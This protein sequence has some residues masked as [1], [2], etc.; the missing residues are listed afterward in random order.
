MSSAIDDDILLDNER[1]TVRR[2]GIAPRVAP[3]SLLAADDHLW[4]IIK[5]GLLKSV[6][7]GREILWREG[8]VLWCDA[9]GTILDDMRN[10]GSLE[11]EIVA[12]HLKPQPR[13]SPPSIP[14][15]AY[16][17]Y[18]NIPGEDLLENEHVIVQ[19]FVVGPGQWEGVHAHVPNMLFI[20][21]KGGQ[22]TARS[23]YEP[24]QVYDQPSPDGSVGWMPT[25]DISEEHQSGNAGSEPIDLIW[26]TLKG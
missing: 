2:V 21:I 19:R 9:P 7:T 6:T 11:L 10:D 25:I 18:P 23:K 8:R 26:V 1:V 3:R 15:H 17:H 20:H 4:V 24:P 5:G 16:L 22:W 13:H 12:V 14:R